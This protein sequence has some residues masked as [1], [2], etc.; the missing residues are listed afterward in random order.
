MITC[1]TWYYL[2]TCKN[3]SI[4]YLQRADKRIYIFCSILVTFLLA[5]RTETVGTDTIVYVSFFHTHNFYYNG[6]PT[7]VMFEVLGRFFH[8]FN[9]TGEWFIFCT[10]VF[11]LIG[12]FYLINK[13]AKIKSL[14]LSLFVL[15]GS[16]FIFYQTYFGAIR[17]CCA[18][19]FYFIAV[20]LWFKEKRSQKEMYI[21]LILIAMAV[22]THGSCLFGIPFILI[23]TYKPITNKKVWYA[24]IIGFYVLCAL[25]IS[26][27]QVI[28]QYTFGFLGQNKYDGYADVNFGQIEMK[29]NRWFNMYLLPFTLIACL[30]IYLKDKNYLK[31][32]WMQLFLW[33]V[34]MNNFFSDNLMW[35][36]L[37]FYLLMFSFI[38][39]PNALKD[40]KRIVK[41]P[42]YVLFI[43]YLLYKNFASLN[44]NF[45]RGIEYGINT[46]VP[47]HSW[48]LPF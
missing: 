18:L 41:I 20:C 45:L 6:A 22:L 42:F 36:R 13:T 2:A 26:Y 27:V 43:T 38:A 14:S 19:S 21:S 7:D 40:E 48:L 33:G 35:G 12:V 24:M 30:L 15:A 25:N 39:I 34:A 28:L 11:S 8:I 17:Q 16:T 29:G 5:T 31:N 44:G 1:Q 46:N 3:R 10:G 23:S 9:G 37:L 47:Y 4:S 32:W